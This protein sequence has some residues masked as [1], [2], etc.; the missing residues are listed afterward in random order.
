MILLVEK[1]LDTLRL[2]FLSHLEDEIQK[3]V[4]T[5]NYDI[6]GKFFFFGNGIIAFVPSLSWRIAHKHT[7]FCS[8]IKL[9]TVLFINMDKGD[10]M[11]E[12]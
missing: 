10:I 2:H 9:P 11:K 6:H 5:G 1:H 8:R 7:P 12:F 4:W 3:M